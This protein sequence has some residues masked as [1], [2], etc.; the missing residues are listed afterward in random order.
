VYAFGGQSRELARY[1]KQLELAYKAGKKKAIISG[2]AVGVTMMLLFCSYSLAF[3]YGSKLILKG[4]NSGGQIL[5]A[6]FSII[7]GGMVYFLLMTEYKG[8]VRIK[9]V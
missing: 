9:K 1:K 6:F 4:E 3:W 8:Q 5:T 2:L 7:T